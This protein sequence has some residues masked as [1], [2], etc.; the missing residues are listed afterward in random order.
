MSVSQTAIISA[1]TAVVTEMM[2]RRLANADNGYRLRILL[3]IEN[4]NPY[5][6]DED[7][8]KSWS[9]APLCNCSDSGLAARGRPIAGLTRAC[10]A[11]AGMATA[12]AT[13]ANTKTICNE[14]KKK[15]LSISCYKLYFLFPCKF[16][17]NRIKTILFS[18]N[19]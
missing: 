19:I 1:Q 6:Y 15:S 2:W 10:G 5:P 14:R 13:T 9:S 7:P 18:A 12:Q 4:T 8:F 11:P 16:L 17:S 3:R